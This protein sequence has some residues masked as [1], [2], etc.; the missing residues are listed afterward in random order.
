MIQPLFTALASFVAVSAASLVGLSLTSAPERATQHRLEAIAA[1][2][3]MPLPRTL[4]LEQPFFKRAIWPGLSLLARMGAS[5]TPKSQRDR[6]ITKLHHAGIYAPQGLQLMLAGK[7]LLFALAVFVFWW[8]HPFNA[9]LGL[10][11]GAAIALLALL[12][13]ERWISSKIRSRQGLLLQAL[14]DGL[15]LVTASV[16]AGLSF[17][18]AV[19]RMTARPSRHGRELREELGRY[20]MDVRMGRTRV[21]A[22]QDLSKR[23][24]INDLE[25]VVAALIQADQLGVGIGQVLRTQSVHLRNKRRQRAQEAALKAPIKMLFPLV[26]FIFPVMF[27]ITLGPA[28]LRIM[29]T[30]ANLHH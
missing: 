4:L 29:D 9:G 6:W 11:G 26:F 7:V 8:L 20:L 25:G 1:G 17:D 22:L 14:P 27:V 5:L 18:G 3:P 15:D 23:C 28:I 30:F 10:V 24:G 2:D 21:E 19:L 13:P 16:E 12:G